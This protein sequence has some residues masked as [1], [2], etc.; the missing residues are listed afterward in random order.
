MPNELWNIS[1]K[2]Y[3]LNIGGSVGSAVQLMVVESAL[4]TLVGVLKVR[5]LT[6]GARTAMTLRMKAV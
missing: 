6:R 1:L 5:A 4:E 3:R 2:R